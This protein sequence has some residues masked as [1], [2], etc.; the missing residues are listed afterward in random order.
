MCCSITQYIRHQAPKYEDTTISDPVV[1]SVTTIEKVHE[2][3]SAENLE[4]HTV[5]YCREDIPTCSR[6]NIS[7]NRV[8]KWYTRNIQGF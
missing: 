5:I 2:I 6:E 1:N 8:L 7:N 4:P 3:G